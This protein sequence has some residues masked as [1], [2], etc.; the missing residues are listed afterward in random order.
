MGAVD[1]ADDS[2]GEF[3]PEKH[4][5][6]D[7]DYWWPM[8]DAE[9][10]GFIEGYVACEEPN[11][12]KK[13]FASHSSQWYVNGINRWYGVGDD[14]ALADHHAEMPIA[15]VVVKLESQKK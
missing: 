15:E 1:H 11:R 7:G 5:I 9:R 13:N 3:Y 4:G 12:L 14:N 2:S 6:F 8:S 10:K